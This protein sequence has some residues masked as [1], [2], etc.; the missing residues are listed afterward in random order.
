MTAKN[1]KEHILS[2]YRQ[3]ESHIPEHMREGYF[4]YLVHG[5]EPGSFAMAVLENNLMQ[6]AG[7]A[8]HINKYALAS[9]AEFIIWAMPRACWGSKEAVGEWIKRG[10]MN[11]IYKED[12]PGGGM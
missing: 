6:A 12:E 8:D 10:G 2:Q 7:T 4:N 11:G 9:H 5:I 1:I 3:Y